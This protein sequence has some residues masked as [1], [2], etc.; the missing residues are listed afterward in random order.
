MSAPRRYHFAGAAQW[1]AGLLA[2]ATP[3]PDGSF[4]PV[5]P[6]AAGTTVQAAGGWGAAIAPEGTAYW[7]DGAQRLWQAEPDAA[8]PASRSVGAPLATA[9]HLAAGRTQL[10]VADTGPALLAYL[11]DTATLRLRVAIDAERIV[12]L[13]ADGRDGAWVLAL[14]GTQALAMHVDCSGLPGACIALASPCGAPIGLAC[15][16]RRLVVLEAGGTRLRW[17]DP[18]RPGASMTIWLGATRPG[19]RATVIGSDGRRRI[20]VAGIDDPAFGGGAWALDCDADGELLASMALAAAPRAIACST[21]QL[22]VT[23]AAAVWRFGLTQ[24]A[25]ARPREACA[26]FVT[27]VLE[28]PPTE[29]RAPWLRAELRAL[30]PPGCSVEIAQAATDNPDRLAAVRALLAE[31]G[32]APG[33]RRQRLDALLDWSAPLR[34]E[35]VE[36]SADDAVTTCALPLH[37][38]RARWLW[39]AVELVAA[40]GAATPRALSLDVL[41]PDESLLQYLPAIYR[42][43]AEQPGDFLHALVAALETSVHGLDDRIATLGRLLAP[44][45]APLPWLDAAARWLGL[46]WDEALDAPA[47][48]ALLAAAPVLLAQRGTRA[49]L[50]ALLAALL[51]AGRARIDDVGVEHGF[52]RLGDA[53]LPALLA[54]WPGD[55]TVLNTRACL[56]RARLPDPA[57]P[58]ADAAAWL[59][60]RVEVQIAATPSE[61]RAWSPWLRPLLEAMTPLTARLALRWVATTAL[62]AIPL[63]DATLSLAADPPGRLGDGATLG[64]SRLQE[65]RGSTLDDA[66]TAPGLTLY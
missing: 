38:L 63:L 5:A 45:Q 3:A 20:V 12:D 54:G 57:Q 36:G 52:A 28:S 21:G 15:V 4:A 16:G 17:V 18:G 27:P 9:R 14:R 11:R 48:R 50:R 49:G 46:P 41:Y 60:G 10:W 59:A 22:L 25:D 29:G 56:G 42:R 55:A 2:R 31:S 66:G 24:A 40:P 47:K 65:R 7:T 32:L 30:L 6:W 23:T 39:I 62:P 37:D 64:R 19:G 35:R 13:A 26:S 44:A 58:A 34:F 61:Q 8:E 51:P 53:R 1:G 43:Q 33:V